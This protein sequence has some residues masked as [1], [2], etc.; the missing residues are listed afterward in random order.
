M[1]KTF[2]KSKDIPKDITDFANGLTIPEM[3]ERINWAM[4]DT[5]AMKLKLGIVGSITDKI[6]ALVDPELLP[7]A[8]KA[9]ETLTQAL[10]DS[11]HGL[12]SLFSV[13]D[14]SDAFEN[15][16]AVSMLEKMVNG[17]VDEQ[18]AKDIVQDLVKK[19]VPPLTATFKACKPALA[20]IRSTAD[21]DTLK[22]TF[23]LV[24]IWIK[25]GANSE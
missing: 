5:G 2:A 17:G 12:D 19:E 20:T 1:F 24:Q 18:A 6:C 4:L 8:L 25:G 7:I 9:K 14:L 21:R 16:T 13:D 22:T 3:Q 15:G 10:L 11:K 23:E